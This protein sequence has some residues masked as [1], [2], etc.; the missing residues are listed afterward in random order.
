MEYKFIQP[1]TLIAEIAELYPAIVEVL[2]VEYG[3]HCVGC[4]ASQFENLQQGAAVH[5]IY[6]ADFDALLERVNKMAEEAE[7]LKVSKIKPKEL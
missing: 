6:D 2:I 3:F 1:E 7:A 5:G 4:F